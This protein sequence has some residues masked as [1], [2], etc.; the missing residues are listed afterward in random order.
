MS[1]RLK[2]EMIVIFGFRVKRDRRAVELMPW[3]VGWIWDE[4]SVSLL[5]S[6]VGGRNGK[7]GN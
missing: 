2:I 3:V 7:A 5:P 4:G 1:G 6:G